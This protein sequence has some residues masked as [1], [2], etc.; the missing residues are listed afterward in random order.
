[1]YNL[2][3]EIINGLA[4]TLTSFSFKNLS[5]KDKVSS[6]GCSVRVQSPVALQL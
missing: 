1:M 6:S 5:T 4:G 2:Q 3:T